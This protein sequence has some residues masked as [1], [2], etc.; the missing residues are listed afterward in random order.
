MVF[1]EEGNPGAFANGVFFA[2]ARGDDQLAFGGDS[3][4]FSF[5]TNIV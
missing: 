3:R 1:L 2:E 5:H 4:G